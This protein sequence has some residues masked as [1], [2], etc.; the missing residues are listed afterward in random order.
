MIIVNGVEMCVIM[1]LYSYI[2]YVIVIRVREDTIYL[3]SCKI[4]TQQFTGYSYPILFIIIANM[5]YFIKFWTLF[6][7]SNITW[8]SGFCVDSLC[9]C[10]MCLFLYSVDILDTFL[11]SGTVVMLPYTVRVHHNKKKNKKNT[12]QPARLFFEFWFFYY[13]FAPCLPDGTKKKKTKK[14]VNTRR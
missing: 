6:H 5:G 11:P 8:S 4:C 7:D 9:A 3:Y 1:R 13:F 12:E 10:I 14:S 2:Q